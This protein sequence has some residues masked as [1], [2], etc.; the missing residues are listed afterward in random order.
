VRHGVLLRRQRAPVQR[1]D[2]GGAGECAHTRQ[3]LTTSAH[4]IHLV[5]VLHRAQLNV[6]LQLHLLSQSG[7]EVRNQQTRG[8]S[9]FS[10]IFNP[11]L[12][13]SLRVC[14]VCDLSSSIEVLE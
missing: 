11:G 6:I 4:Q 10:G 1:G 5:L 13:I 8:A 14:V 2:G 12:A 3:M 9:E 7:L